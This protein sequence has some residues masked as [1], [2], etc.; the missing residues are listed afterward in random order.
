M[1]ILRPRYMRIEVG[2]KMDLVGLTVIPRARSSCWI[3][4]VGSDRPKTSQS[5]MPSEVLI[6]YNRHMT[7]LGSE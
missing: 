7:P 4:S 2:V 5:V 3:S 6:V 1:L